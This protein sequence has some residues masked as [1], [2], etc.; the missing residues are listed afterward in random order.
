MRSHPSMNSGCRF[1]MG[2]A[3]G[4]AE[5]R[6]YI[7]M[8]NPELLIIKQRSDSAE[9]SCSECNALFSVSQNL[10]AIEELH[11]LFRNHVR[12]KH[13]QEGGG[14]PLEPKA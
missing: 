7:R 6:Y 8:G 3:E 10:L 1:E 4:S 13:G 2:S 12:R 9:G 11:N 5:R 14:Q